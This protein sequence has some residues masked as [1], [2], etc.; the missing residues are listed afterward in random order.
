[1]E[2]TASWFGVT[3]H[4]G[5]FKPAYFSLKEVWTGKR[6]EFPL[7]DIHLLTGIGT[8]NDS[9]VYRYRVVSSNNKNL[10]LNYE[11]R[12]LRNDFLWEVDRVKIK[13]GELNNFSFRLINNYYE[14][15]RRTIYPVRNGRDLRYLPD[16][17]EEGDRIYL[18]VYDDQNHVVTAS[19]P[20]FPRWK[21]Q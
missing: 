19:C 12:V 2:G 14:Y 11:W 15:I 6:Q 3:D 8:G 16:K 21:E 17:T 18:Y 7:T 5:R 1:M 10:D 20:Y 4:A 9:W 13:A